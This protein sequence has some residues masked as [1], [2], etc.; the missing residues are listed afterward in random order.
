MPFGYL[1]T[2]CSY[3]VSII[4]QGTVLVLLN[5]SCVFHDLQFY[6]NFVGILDDYIWFIY[7]FIYLSV[8]M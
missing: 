7:L 2:S 5:N 3:L 4:S 1:F 8:R 6:R